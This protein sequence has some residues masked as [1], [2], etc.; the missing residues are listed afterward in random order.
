[1][2]LVGIILLL[3]SEWWLQVLFFNLKWFK[4]DATRIDKSSK[5]LF[6]SSVLRWIIALFTSLKGI[7]SSSAY[8]SI[9]LI[10]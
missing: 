5:F 7:Y 8:L 6:E 3:F 1:M 9:F 4:K 2:S 10:V